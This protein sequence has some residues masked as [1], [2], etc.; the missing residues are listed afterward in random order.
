[1]SERVERYCAAPLPPYRYVP[2][3]TPHP[4][5]DPRGYAYGA[6]ERV[7]VI[8]AGRWQECEA[9]LQAIDLFNLGYY[10]EAHEGLEA[11][12]R[13]A[14]STSDLGVLLQ[15]VIQGAAALLK[16]EMGENEGARRLA[17]KGCEKLRAGAGVW[18]GIDRRQLAEELAAFIEG[19][20]SVAPVIRLIPAP[21]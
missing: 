9:Y 19:Q 8:D 21:R 15:G 11:L 13:G 5:R 12:W 6:E 4:V 17:E 18:L 3:Q 16:H 1:M 2:G 10:W 14:G 7:V 20:G